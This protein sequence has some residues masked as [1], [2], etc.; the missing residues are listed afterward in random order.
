MKFTLFK[1]IGLA[2]VTSAAASPMV[3]DELV[4][5]DAILELGSDSSIIEGRAVS[6][7]ANYLI[8]PKTNAVKKDVE[9]FTKS[10]Q[11]QAGKTKVDTLTD[12]N[13]KLLACVIGSI[14]PDAPLKTKTKA[15]GI[16]KRALK[17]D[18]KAQPEL[19]MFSTAPDKKAS[20]Y[21]FDEKAGQGVTI[22]VLDEGFNLRHKEFTSSPGRKRWIFSKGASGENDP[23][24]HGSC[25]A[26]KALGGTVGVA[27]KADLVAVKLQLTSW[28]LLKAWQAVV[29]DVKQNRL[30]GKAVVSN[31]K[32]SV[33]WRVDRNE[34]WFRDT[35]EALLKDLEA[36]DVVVVS[37][38][39]NFG[40]H[41]DVSTYPLLFADRTPIIVTGAVDNKGHLAPFSQGGPLVTT[42]APGVAVKCA[43]MSGTSAYQAGEESTGT[44]FSTPA[45]AGLAAYFLSLDS[46]RPRLQVPGSVARN[47]K[48]LIQEH[49]YARV[50]GGPKVAWN[51]QTLL[52]N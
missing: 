44:S 3:S 40:T 22:Y 42:T 16:A 2:L 50:S 7:S 32:A 27:P 11:S 4:V 29:L 1:F 46:L 8:Y 39:G 49:H 47:V 52:R 30:Q 51:A 10:L 5:K 28:S 45:V 38:S 12:V 9:A 48:A 24:G 19:Q 33:G 14:A 20:G 43:A 34:K 17:T 26:S 31:S 25:C 23:D 15:S 36:L 35:L 41:I 18:K 21:T 6:G 13:G 37:S